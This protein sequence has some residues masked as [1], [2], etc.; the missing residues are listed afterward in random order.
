MI[1]FL[2]IF[3]EIFVLGGLFLVYYLDL[4]LGGIIVVIVVVILIIFIMINKGWKG[5]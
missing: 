5:K 2:V 3:G 1:L 4:V